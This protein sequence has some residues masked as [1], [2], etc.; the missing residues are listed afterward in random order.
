MAAVS[1]PKQREKANTIEG[2]S[3]HPRLEGAV[4]AIV[5]GTKAMKKET[6]ATASTAETT[7][8]NVAV[9]AAHV[10]AVVAMIVVV[11]VH[12]SLTEHHQKRVVKLVKLFIILKTS[13]T[14]E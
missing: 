8:A 13:K 10:T 2:E 6:T 12:G 4:V 14:S 5:T 1:S 3:E 11:L 9:A 7:A